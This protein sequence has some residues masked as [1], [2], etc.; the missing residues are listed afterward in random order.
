[1]AKSTFSHPWN[2][3]AEAIPLG[4]IK[5]IQTTEKMEMALSILFSESQS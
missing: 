1:M 3:I 4:L 5:L 2:L